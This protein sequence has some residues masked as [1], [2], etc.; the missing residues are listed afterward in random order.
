MSNAAVAGGGTQK[1]P[2]LWGTQEQRIQIAAI[3]VTLNSK[4]ATVRIPKNGYLSKLLFRFVG[5]VTVGTGGSATT[6]TVPLY[7]LIQSYVL[8]YNGGFQYR[9]MDGESMYVMNLLRYAGA[10]DP[11][12]SSPNWKQYPPQTVTSTTVGF[13]LE[14]EVGLN[15][16]VNADKYLLAAQARNADIT[17]DVTFGGLTS[18]VANTEVLTA[19]TGTLFVEGL[20]LLDPPDYNT[21][22]QPDL[23][24]VQQI[25]TDTSYTNVVVGDNIVPIVPVNGPKYLQLAFKAQ[26]NNVP[27]PQGFSSALTRV[28]LRINNGLNRYDM[29]P[30]ALAQENIRQLGRTS[31]GTAASS[32]NA[33]LPPGWY[34]LD[35]LDDSSINNCVSMVGRNV[36]STEKIANLWLIPTVAT[37][38]TVTNSIIKLIKRVEMPAVG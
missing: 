2:F 19:I 34:F 35:F 21:F 26:F 7:N 5:S 38:T 17:L 4:A 23:S 36:I 15:T 11:V 8:S 1:Y 3:P 13:C 9:S 10:Q 25:I 18:I 30:Q 6:A 31:V 14:D 24:K 33:A 29:S 22:N 28:Q 27:D 12:V 16:Q 32:T 20:Y 37:G